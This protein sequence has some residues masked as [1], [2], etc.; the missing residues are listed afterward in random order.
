MD[1]FTFL[2]IFTCTVIVLVC[3]TCRNDKK[4]YFLIK[5][6]L[7]FLS[8]SDMASPMVVK[9]VGPTN[10]NIDP[11]YGR[12]PALDS[13]R[14][15]WDGIPRPDFREHFFDILSAGLGT[16]SE[17]GNTLYTTVMDNDTAT[18]ECGQCDEANECKNPSGPEP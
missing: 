7:R 5:T 8:Y 10:P 14:I 6:V 16:I 1:S 9:A 15:M 12:I 18:R 17:N 4:G 3:L 13:K 11:Y 2:V